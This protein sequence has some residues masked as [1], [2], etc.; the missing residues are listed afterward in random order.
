MNKTDIKY[1]S[2]IAIIVI[3]MVVLE[4]TEDKPIDWR[5]T[6]E[7]SEK[8]PYATYVLYNNLENLFPE[9]K[10][11]E[12]SQSVYQYI[13][14]KKA[15]KIPKNKNFIFITS[16]FYPDK[17]DT[18]NLFKLAENGNNIFISADRFSSNF[19]DSLNFSTDY[20]GFF[21]QDSCVLN[22]ENKKIAEK[23]GYIYKKAFK[24]FHFLSFDT[25]KT[26][27]L[28]TINDDVNYIKIPYGKGFF[29]INTQPVAF[30]NYALLNEENSE[31]ACKVFSYLPVNDVIWDEFYKPYN[32][33][34]ETPLR[35]VFSNIGLKSAYFVILISVLMYMFFTAKRRQRIIPVINP[36]KNTSLEFIETVA[37]L[38]F[39]KKNHKDTAL[40]KYKY[41]LEMLRSKYYINIE[42]SQKQDYKKTAEKT[43]KSIEIIENI[44]KTATQIQNSETIS[45][46]QLELFNNYI[47]DFYK[48]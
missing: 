33:E 44:F 8:I 35:Y 7:N 30:T 23:N 45:D 19:S 28:G 21:M 3:G 42:N 18:E 10:I 9:K 40:K 17:L 37:G 25:T 32:E 5:V 41:F 1:Y 36:L 27:V 48:K 16:M 38:Y 12:N 15:N 6:L 34:K 4:L 14:Y 13:T 2:F 26:I 22:F 11:I 39:H 46:K 24:T 20:G 43:G 47:E 31:Y 29:F